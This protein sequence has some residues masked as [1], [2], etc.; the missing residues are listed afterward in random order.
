MGGVGEG[1]IDELAMMEE[2]A[3]G[4]QADSIK[5]TVFINFDEDDD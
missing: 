1:V 3:M 5:V 4:S 2:D